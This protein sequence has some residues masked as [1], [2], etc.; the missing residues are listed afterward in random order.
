MTKCM[1][2]LVLMAG[3]AF[4]QYK[5]DSAGAPPDGLAPAVSAVLAQP[6]TRIHNPDGSVLCEVWM[7]SEV[8][9][10]TGSSEA[11]VA[12]PSIPHG[13]LLGVIRFPAN[14]SDRRGQ[15]IKPGVYTLRFSL[16]PVDGAHQGVAPQRDFLILVPAAD[17]SD[18]AAMP[19]YAELMKWSQ[20]AS[21]TPHPAVLSI[22]P[23]LEDAP[24]P[25]FV[26]EGEHDWMFNTKAGATPIGIILVGTF[27]G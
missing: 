26:K 9:A 6:G 8:P 27:E 22:A 20:K 23:P 15:T 14:G 16:Y 2:A 5:L 17:D 7:R 10:G 13:A 1:M 4:P 21:G 25:G 19:E 3:F 12:Y 18:P 11:N 24:N